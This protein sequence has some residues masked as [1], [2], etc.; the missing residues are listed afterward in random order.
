MILFLKIECRKLKTRFQGEWF[1]RDIL[2]MSAYNNTIIQK[3]VESREPVRCF[4]H[5]Y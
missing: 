1:G 2:S 4:R 5:V 3:N